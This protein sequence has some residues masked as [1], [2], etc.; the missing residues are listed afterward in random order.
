[1][2]PRTAG[3]LT[4]L[5]HKLRTIRR[6]H[7]AAL[8][9]IESTFRQVGLSHLFES[10]GGRKRGPAASSSAAATASGKRG[11]GKA[12]TRAAGKTRGKAKAAPKSGRG[13]KG[14]AAS[15]KRGKRARYDQTAEEFI[16]SFLAKNRSATTSEIRQHWQKQGRG[17]K[18]ENSL[19][20]LVKNGKLVRT[21]R[22]GQAGSSYSLASAPSTP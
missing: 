10:G 2:A 21:P 20:G 5:I 17:G 11:R 1:M 16:L 12:K 19:T 13:A 6:Q 18:A 22:P 7:E 9:E 3:E 14:K 8:A 4:D 15:G